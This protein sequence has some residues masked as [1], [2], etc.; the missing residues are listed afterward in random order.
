MHGYIEA[1]NPHISFSARDVGPLVV[2][3]ST[4]SYSIRHQAMV[5]SVCL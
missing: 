4:P 2:W 1:K 3:D 5:T